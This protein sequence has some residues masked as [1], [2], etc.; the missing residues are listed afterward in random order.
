MGIKDLMKV[1]KEYCED[2]LLVFHLSEFEGMRIAI[3]ISIFLYKYIRTS[4]EIRWMNTFI[5]LLC[6]LKQYRIKGVCIFDGPDPPPEKKLEQD[7][8]RAE[9]EKQISRLKECIRMRDMLQDEYAPFDEEPTEQI[10]KECRLLIS[11][12]RGQYDRTNYC[13]ANDICSS[14]NET[15]EK[16]EKQTMPIT[17]KHRK[18]AMDIV[19]MFGFACYQ[20]DGEAET[21]CAYLCAKGLVDAVLTEDTDVLAY[22]TPLMIAFKDFKL[23]DRKVYGL[24]MPS[25]LDY[26]DM[27]Q[28]EFTDLCI[29]LSCDYNNRARGFPPDGRNRKKPVG[30][31][32][33]GAWHMIREYRRL[34]KVEKY[35]VD[36]DPLKY[37]R[38]RELFSLPKRVKKIRGGILPIDKEPDWGA[39]EDLISTNRLTVKI[40]YISKKWK[41]AQ[42]T[43]QTTTS[44]EE[45]SADDDSEVFIKAGSDAPSLDSDSQDS[46]E[47]SNDESSIDILDSSE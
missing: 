35:L 34:E 5:L 7:R 12:R 19:K 38:C 20:A 16:L 8:R 18:Q 29:L 9:G 28:E 26:L 10:K 39:L 32:V 27:T 45:S 47:D 14:L 21:L 22:G 36:P 31:G 42:I 17:D 24:H 33:K 44:D 30:I 11:K 2:M 46:D 1:I 43:F 6:A 41:P 15:I 25:I 23:S 13:D 4:G 40:D 3:D 37:R